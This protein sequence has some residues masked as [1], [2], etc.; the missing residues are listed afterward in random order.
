MIFITCPFFCMT[1]FMWSFL[2][3]SF[4]FIRILFLIMKW[5]M[6]INFLFLSH[7]RHL[8]LCY[9]TAW[10]IYR[11]GDI[12]YLFHSSTGLSSSWKFVLYK[13][14]AVFTRSYKFR[15]IGT[16]ISTVLKSFWNIQFYDSTQLAFD[17]LI[18]SWSKF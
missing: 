3:Y 1:N 13:S 2:W 6:K 15:L 9:L 5:D 8:R 4:R 18:I 16:H 10:A 11:V 17:K 7:G 14:G 12:S